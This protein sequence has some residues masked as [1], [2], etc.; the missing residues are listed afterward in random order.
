M[1]KNKYVNITDAKTLVEK[2]ERMQFVFQDLYN[3]YPN[4]LFQ[5]LNVDGVYHSLDDTIRIITQM[6]EDLQTMPSIGYG[7]DILNPNT[8]DFKRKLTLNITLFF[9]VMALITEIVVNKMNIDWFNDFQ[10]LDLTSRERRT[11]CIF[12]INE[13][14]LTKEKVKTMINDVRGVRKYKRIFENL[15]ENLTDFMNPAIE[16]KIVASDDHAV[17]YHDGFVYNTWGDPPY[18]LE[19]FKER[20]AKDF[21]LC[22]ISKIIPYEIFTN[23]EKDLLR[24]LF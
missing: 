9:D 18:T 23:E 7:F 13:K 8:V 3:F 21:N 5:K 15:D 24:Q 12:F 17:A 2:L 22:C 1:C 14:N 10:T 20:F 11:L 4:R 6:K 19:Q 16:R